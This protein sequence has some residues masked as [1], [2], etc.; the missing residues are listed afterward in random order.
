MSSLVLGQSVSKLRCTKTYRN[1]PNIYVFFV[2][3]NS[4]KKLYW[5]TVYSQLKIFQCFCRSLSSLVSPTI[6]SSYRHTSLHTYLCWRCNS[7]LHR[8]DQHAHCE[9]LLTLSNSDM[10]LF[11]SA[12]LCLQDLHIRS[13]K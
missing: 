13:L 7:R 10:H 9:I 12:R 4:G 8:Q 2:P 3:G 5:A 11:L 6:M 1:I